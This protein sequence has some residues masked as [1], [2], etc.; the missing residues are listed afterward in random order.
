MSTI[1]SAEETV[2]VRGEI[3]KSTHRMLRAK[4]NK[5]EEDTDKRPD[6]TEIVAAA[7]NEWATSQQNQ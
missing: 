3:P 6:M 2:W 7:L 4:Q 5:Q 1:A